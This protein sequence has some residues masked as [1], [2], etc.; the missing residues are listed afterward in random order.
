MSEIELLN[1]EIRP[2]RSLSDRGFI[3]LISFVTAIN[4]IAGA[5]FLS[6][7]AT[8]VPFFL[9]LD[10]VAVLVAFA[11]SYASAR[12]IERVVITESLV[13]LTEETP[14]RRV[15]IWEG[16]TAFTRLA[17][18]AEADRLVTLSLTVS[19]KEARIGKTLGPKAL[20]D[21]RRQLDAALQQARRPRTLAW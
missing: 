7:G 14:H 21:L 2:H 6:M 15:L 13:R 8:L 18:E 3:I 12:R 11:V 1:V 10:V 20:E 5:V 4:C 17:A 16:P 19:G 9:A